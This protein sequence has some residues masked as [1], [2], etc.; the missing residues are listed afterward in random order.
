MLRATLKSL[1]ARKLRLTLST[2][3]VVL[4]VMFVSGSLV[5]TDTLGRTFDNLFANIYTYT[6]VQ[7]AAKSQVASQGGESGTLPFPA[8]TVDEVAKVDGVAKATGQVFL[9]G[10]VPIGRNGKVV[11]NQTGQ[12]FGANWIGE[13]DLVKLVEGKAPA[14]DNEIVVNRGL[15][16]SAG[17]KVGD[18]MDVITRDKQRKTYTIVG[19]MQYAGGRD[20][21]AGESTIFFTTPTAQKAM[22]G[23]EDQFN[24]IDVKAEPGVTDEKLRD[25]VKAQLGDAFL[26]RTGQELSE[27]SSKA[28]KGFL[29]YFNYVLLGFGAVALLVGIF[30]ILNTFSIIVAQRTQ[31]LALLRAMGASRGQVMR[32]VLLE[33]L[34]IGVVGSAFG[35]AVGLGLGALGAYLF[36]GLADGAEVAGL[37]FPVSAIVASFAIG[38]LVT[39]VAA[40]MPALKAA[41]VAPIAAMRESAA[42]DRP[43]TKVT[44]AG[45]VVTALAIGSLTWGL[46]GA[47][48]GTLWLVFGGVLGL[49]VGVALLTPVISK[50]LVAALGSVFSWTVPGKLGRRN[51]SRNPRRTAITAGAVM[52][53]IAI[54]TA[55]STIFSS[56]STAI[57]DTLDKDLQADLVVLGQQTSAIPP[58]ITP[59]ELADIKALP[60]AGTVAARTADA[61]EVNGEQNFVLSYEDVGAAMTV[62]KLK[63]AEGRIDRLDS[64]EFI[65]DKKTAENRKLKLGDTITVTF[66]KTGDKTLKL[67]GISGESAI[68]G[69]IVVSYADATTGFSFPQPWQAFIS[70]KDGAS[71]SATKDAVASIIKDNPEVNVYTKDEFVE[72][73]QKGFDVALVVVQV[74]LLIALAISVLGVINTL[75]LSVIERTRELGMLRAVGLRRRQTWLM[76]T[77]ESVVITVFGTVLG[78]AVG[79]GL[80]AA[81]VTALKEVL[82]FGA[83]TLPWGLM[84][85]YFIASL[86]IGAV[87]GLIPSIRAVRLNVLNAI[88]YE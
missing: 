33:A 52:I 11:A 48:D 27:E 26:A 14:A 4:S 37:G 22:L 67:V 43:L 47:G 79:A 66:A 51:S 18:S 1:L 3:A 55:I 24:V 32:S 31:E 86:F 38:I 25:N 77:T 71:V 65:V 62:L 78:L 40:L 75:L 63:A 5:L 34:L 57:G 44:I 30:L 61:V 16:K 54:V 82:G 58:V 46:T 88:A 12:Q 60:G 20:S 29:N 72:T 76:V 21:M 80:G 17:V 36:V 6:D 15:A 59:E 9:N 85:V 7:V 39:M 68:A 13:D 41:R 84:V 8:A 64:G 74:L 10:A 73:N 42:T 19:E 70:V 50:P 23:A 49:L 45:C 83:V 56:L 87:A 81:I 35:F 2:L 69:G 28:I 53:G